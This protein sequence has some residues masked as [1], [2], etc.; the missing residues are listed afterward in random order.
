[1]QCKTV[2]ELETFLQNEKDF[3][4]SCKAVVMSY[5]YIYIY[6]YVLKK[7][8]HYSVEI[9]PELETETPYFS[10]RLYGTRLVKCPLQVVEKTL[11]I[12][13]F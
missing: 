5:L 12:L 13:F 6:M 3:R 4:N 9:E 1:M 8:T 7:K 2:A 10:S 11:A